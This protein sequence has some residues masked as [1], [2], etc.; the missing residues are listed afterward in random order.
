MSEREELASILS[1]QCTCDGKPDPSELHYRMA[2]AVLSAGFR[3]PR[4]VT[5]VEELEAL[6]DG[7]VIRLSN[8][9]VAGKFA[10]TNYHYWE[11]FGVTGDFLSGDFGK[12]IP[13]TVLYEGS[14]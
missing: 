10:I 6:P 4:V 3:K 11:V 7:A 5:T 1:C 12:H 14:E 13:V 8:S 2:D 9:R